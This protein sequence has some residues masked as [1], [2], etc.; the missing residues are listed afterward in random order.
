MFS[1]PHITAI[2]FSLMEECFASY[3]MCLHSAETHSASAY[4]HT[5]NNDRVKA[6]AIFILILSLIFMQ[7]TGKIV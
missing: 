7:I 4:Y 3:V 1:N 6:R 2:I 5:R